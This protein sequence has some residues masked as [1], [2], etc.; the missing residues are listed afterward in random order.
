MQ[1]R[2]D[3]MPLNSVSEEQQILSSSFVIK[4]FSRHAY[5]CFSQG[6]NI[7][8]S[9]NMQKDPPYPFLHTSICPYKYANVYYFKKEIFKILFIIFYIFYIFNVPIF[10]TMFVFDI[11]FSHRA[12]FSVK[13]NSILLV[14]GILVQSVS[15]SLIIPRTI[16]ALLILF[17]SHSY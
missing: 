12:I 3:E 16:F 13:S 14:N 17:N 9:H 8:F 5:F 4:K 10:V 6:L 1:S 7:R 11:S 15:D 2:A